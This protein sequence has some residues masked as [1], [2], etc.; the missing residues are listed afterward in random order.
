M[1]ERAARAAA[2]ENSWTTKAP[3]PTARG[4]LQV[5][6]ANGKIYAIGGSGPIGVNEEYDPATDTWTTK[7]SMPDPQ[8]S[9]AMAV[10]QGKIY[11]I[12]G[13]PT[14][15]SGASGA[16]K[17]YDP[18]TDSWETKAPMPTERYGLQAQVVNDK[19][20]LIGGRRLL[21]HNLG[22]EELNVTEVYDPASDTWS[23]G[24]SMPNS[25]SYVSAMVGDK[26]FVIGSSTQIYNPK[27]DTWSVGTP[28][29]EKIIL[30]VNGE[31]AA[32]AATTGTMAPKRI[33]V[34]DGSSLQVYNPQNDSWTFGSAPPTSRQY[35]GIAVVNDLLYFIGGFTYT[36]PGFFNDFATNE[37]YTPFGY[38]SIPIVSVLSP[39][40]QTYNESSASLVFIVNKPVNW[41]G[42]S[43]DG[44]ETVTIT[45][46]IT[47]AGLSN[48]LHNIT[49]YAKDEFGNTGTSET[50]SFSVAE[51]P[52]PVA[53][54]A[55]ASVA[56]VAVVG[57]GLLVYF[58]KR[59][60]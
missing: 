48:G 29:P 33:Y 3:M 46:N 59:K 1:A 58:R 42:Y 16:N 55:A 43:L 26:V 53:P 44:K 22:F 54:V 27:T 56:T 37:Q 12:G 14:G 60:H 40:N 28:P 17:V 13:M 7:A 24:A 31:S 47:V 21:G 32:A 49:V 18:A 19:I 39:M 9:F 35:L 45:G 30:G 34:Y 57:V 8:Q 20:Y 11:C 52:F 23:T 50:I 15:F 51:E 38:G 25:A 36:P 6:V 4:Y 10:C 5:A 41:A 2:A